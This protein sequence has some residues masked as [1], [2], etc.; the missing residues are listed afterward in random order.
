MVALS[1][2]SLFLATTALAAPSQRK[3]AARGGAPGACADVPASAF[4]LPSAF[5]ALAAAPSYTTMGFGVQNYTCSAAGTYTSLGAVGQMFDVSCLYG[6]D[7]FQT[8]QQDAYNFWKQIPCNDPLQPYIAEQV[9][10]KW[11]IPVI[12]QHYFVDQGSTLTPVFDFSSTGKNKGNSDAIFFGKKAFDVTSP[13][14]AANVD[15][16]QLTQVPPY[17]LSTTVYRVYTVL[18]Q[19]PASCTPGS[20]N[21]SVKYATKYLLV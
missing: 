11:G 14:G 21:I 12:G 18:G 2:L 3:I 17:G 5:N 15:W 6:K 20:P 16:L 10:Q 8:I 1:L 13:E 4:N 19:P 9:N 7:E